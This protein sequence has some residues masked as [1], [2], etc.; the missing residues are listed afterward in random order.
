MKVL[1]DNYNVAE[2]KHVVK[3]DALAYPRKMICQNCGSELEYEKED[4]RDGYLGCM[5]VDCP[6]C[7][8]DNMIDDHEDNINLT[9]DNVQ[10][11]THFWH[12]CKE[13]GAVD[14]CNNEQVKQYIHKAI[15]Y[16]RKNP[17]EHS[18]CACTGN[19]YISVDKD[20]GDENY[21]VVVTDN[22]YDTYIPFEKQ[23]YKKGYTKDW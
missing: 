13:N 11:P 18:W 15:D 21:W 17:N 7:E 10:F 6:L 12:T 8:Y 4:V 5:F 19:L 1:K 9:K 14:V 20:E 23:D 3:H 16:F 2:T 22:Y